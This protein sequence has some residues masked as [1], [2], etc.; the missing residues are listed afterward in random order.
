VYSHLTY[1]IVP[2]EAVEITGPDIVLLE[3]VIAVQPRVVDG[4][5][6]AV[7]VH[8][9]EPDV[10]G[11]FVD[12]FRRLTAEARDDPS[13]FYHGFSAMPE[14]Q[15]TVLAEATWDSI[16]AVNLREHILPSRDRADII[17]EKTADH[18]VR[19]VRRV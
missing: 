16:N 14:E 15:L 11:W 5:D 7:Y 19:A 1:D 3:G 8:A 2:E 6:V 9:D 17:V 18:S 4:V 13:S 12:R 10:R